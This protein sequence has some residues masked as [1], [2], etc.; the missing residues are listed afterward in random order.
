MVHYT[1]IFQFYIHIPIAIFSVIS[2]EQIEQ[3]CIDSNAYILTIIKDKHHPIFK[4]LV[5][6]FKQKGVEQ[7]LQSVVLAIDYTKE[8]LS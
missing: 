6:E 4:R 1:E 8:Y 2:D 7:E 5:K 3:D